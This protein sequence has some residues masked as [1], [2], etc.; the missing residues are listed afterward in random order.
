MNRQKPILY[1]VIIPTLNEERYIGA[2]LR[3]LAEQ[4]EKHF[5]VIVVDAHS[6]DGTRDVVASFG[7]KLPSLQILKSEKRL[8]AEQRNIGAASARYDWLVFVDADSV[9]LPYFFERLSLYLAHHRVAALTTW[10]SP[11]S[12]IRK[13]ALLTLFANVTIESSVMLSRPLAPGPLTIVTKAAH[14]KIGGY[15]GGY[16]NGEDVDYGR[17]LFDRGIP[18]HVLR[19]TLYI[20]SLRRFRREGTLRMLERFSV[21]ALLVLVTKKP[22]R[23][24]SGYDLG[25]ALY[26]LK[27]SSRL[28]FIRK[29]ERRLRKLMKEFV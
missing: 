18:L 23:Y 21:T 22:Q 15:D 27:K 19:E 10:F 12:E 4:T 26:S 3:S 9:L 2:L 25:G 17:R 28:S 7:T 16:R 11:D 6:K 1:S 5:E 13:D 29:Y 14:T 24:I 20:W 8:I